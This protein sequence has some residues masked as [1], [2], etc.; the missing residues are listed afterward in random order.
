MPS[1][2]AVKNMSALALTAASRP[3]DLN[4]FR[5][6]N[7]EDHAR[8]TA[9]GIAAPDENADLLPFIP[10]LSGPDQFQTLSRLLATRG[11]RSSRIEKILSGNFLRFARDV[12][13]I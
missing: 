7:A 5:I 4:A 2:F 1:G 3:I 10:E 11:H 12:W 13:G 9:A 8:R 6:A